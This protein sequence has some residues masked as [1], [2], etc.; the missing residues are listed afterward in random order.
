MYIPFHKAHITD[1]EIN[2]V[3][4]ALRSGWITMGPKVMEFEKKFADFIN[5]DS[6]K[7]INALLV[8]SCTAALHLALKAIGLKAGD[9]VIL[10][11][12][13]FIATAEVVTYFNAKPVLC[14]IDYDTMLM[15]VNKIEALITDK[16]KAIIPVHFA[17]QP[18]D[19]DQILDIARKYNLKVIEDAAH[20]F[21]AFYKDK[22]VGTIGDITCF[23]FYA[24]KTLAMGEGGAITTDN[25]EY[26]K[27][28][29]INRL[30][31]INRDAWDRY[32]MKG[33]WYYEVVDNGLKYNSTDINAAMG[34]AQL[35]K[36]EW[37]MKEREKI[38]KM[39]IDAFKDDER[40]GLPVLKDDRVSA[41]HLFVI[42]VKN[43]DHLI[44]KLKEVGV[45]TS[46]HFIPV[47]KHPYYR[48]NFGYKDADYPIANRVFE[49]SL[50]LPIWP[51]MK[52]EEVEYV[53]DM[54][55]RYA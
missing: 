26:L 5:R 2:L 43:R 51:G 39:Y 9:E 30:H 14:D 55:K 28:I 41:W 27:S 25:E 33:S 17:G 46:V 50:S 35:N 21:P 44:E 47:H 52:D 49:L 8:N 23:S 22:P 15:N 1:E 53:V 3:V 12:N 38:A 42:K 54:V 18:C 6:S 40:I 11:T 36:A 20:S 48:S 10:P 24:T 37:M 34:L 32:T 13:T 19:M 4:D 29:K 16:T 7:Q 45:G 31:G